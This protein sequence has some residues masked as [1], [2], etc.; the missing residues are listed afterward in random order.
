MRYKIDTTIATVFFE[1]FFRSL[2]KNKPGHV[3]AAVRFARARL[4]PMSYMWSAPVVFSTLHD[5]PLFPFLEDPPN[6]PTLEAYEKT[7]TQLW[8]NLAKVKWSQ[9]D[10]ETFNELI[11]DWHQSLKEYDAEMTATMKEHK[12]AFV[13]PGFVEVKP[14]QEI[15]IPVKLFGELKNVEEIEGR[16]TVS[17]GPTV[18]SALQPSKRLSDN[19]FNLNSLD[20]NSGFLI[21][22]SEDAGSLAEGELFDIVITVP[23]ETQGVLPVTISKLKTKPP[24]NVCQGDNAIVF[25][26]P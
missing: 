1:H 24:M 13:A 8:K 6:C 19:K 21:R 11:S 10:Q 23:A 7:R 22:H 4:A 2:L 16:I 25:P 12:A 20:N 14:G 3:E 5:E 17:S 9:R 18:V 26:L 15:R